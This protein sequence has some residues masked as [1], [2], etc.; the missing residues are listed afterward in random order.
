M[1]TPDLQFDN[2]Q[3]SVNNLS[4]VCW[5]FRCHIGAVQLILCKDILVLN[6][7]HADSLL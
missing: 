1:G 4:K 3:L 2:S 5:E 6:S 7:E